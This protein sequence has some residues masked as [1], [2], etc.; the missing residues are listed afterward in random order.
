MANATTQDVVENI[1]RSGVV[2]LTGIATVLEA[3]GGRTVTAD[4]HGSR[5]RSR[6]GWQPSDAS[7]GRPGFVVPARSGG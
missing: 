5:C 7:E 4:R 2:T 1:R 6:G 3:R